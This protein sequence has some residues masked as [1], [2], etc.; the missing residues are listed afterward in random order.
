MAGRLNRVRHR[1]CTR[2]TNLLLRASGRS[3]SGAAWLS[4]GDA[5]RAQFAPFCCYGIRSER[6]LV[7]EVH[8][9][10]AYRGFCGIGRTGEV[11]ERS[12]FSKARHGG[13]R[14]SDAFRL[15]FEGV[16]QACL[17]P[18]PVGGETL[19]TDASVIEAD[20][21]V[22]RSTR[23]SRARRMRVSSSFSGASRGPQ[24]RNTS[25]PVAQRHPEPSPD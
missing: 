25:F 7:E 22:A 18:G 11:P 24:T 4:R 16:L 21:R 19:P 23:L 2:R 9:N 20:A 12:T 3:V 5:G 15:L 17:R 6:W 14:D 1:L 8:L 13:F 10:L